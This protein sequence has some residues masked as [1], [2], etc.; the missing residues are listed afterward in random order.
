MDQKRLLAAIAISIAIL[1]SFQLLLPKAPPRPA[2][3]TAAQVN[4]PAPPNAPP[5]ADP[6]FPGTEPESVP[7]PRESPRVPI[8]AAR[9]RGSINLRGGQLDDLVLTDYHEEVDPASP[10]VRVLEPAYDPE[11]N[12][13]QFGWTS[14]TPG[15]KLPDAATLWAVSAGQSLSQATPV[16]LTWD[17]GAG[18]VFSLKYA[19]DADY[20]FTV[21][22][23]VRNAAGT[24]VAL[25][26]ISRVR[27][28]Y[29]PVTAGYYILHEGPIAVLDGSVYDKL[30][31]DTMKTDGDKHDGLAYSA[32]TIGGWA[33]ITDKYW[34]TAL[35]PDQAAGETA[36]FRHGTSAHGDRYEVDFTTAAAQEVAP[37]ADLITTARA[38]AGAKEVRLLDRYEANE[39]IPLFSY[40]VDWGGSS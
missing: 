5:R 29:K 12:Y 18:L 2:L 33:G 7:A 27:R 11:P 8:N 32:A 19:V 13:L 6:A 35:V 15:V 25:R 17:N 31:Y 40:A 37:G 39:H 22:Q 28:D 38:F 1:L 16:T 20:L 10:L 26:P 21:E 14:D 23:G 4:Q 36:S 24:A 3:Q 30:G 34:L 9:V